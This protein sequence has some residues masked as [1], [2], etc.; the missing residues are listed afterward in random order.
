MAPPQSLWAL[1]ALGAVLLGDRWLRGTPGGAGRSWRW[2][3]RAEAPT[4]WAQRADLAGLAVRRPV[5]GRV[6][7]GRAR[8]RLV[9][10]EPGQAL[11]VVGPT[12]S[13]KTSGLVVPALL[14]WPGPVVAAS[15]KADLVRASLQARLRLGRVF[16]YDPVQ[17]AGPGLW[18]DGAEPVGWTPVDGATSWAGARR[19]ASALASVAR[20][21][22]GDLRDG[23]FWYQQAAKLLGPLLHAAALG[24]L[25]VTEV[26]RW[27]ETQEAEEPG[28][29]LDAAGAW[30]ALQ[31]LRACW[32]R[33][34][35]QRSA[36]LATA[37]LVLE[38]YAEPGLA[39]GPGGPP[40]DPAALSAGCDSLFLC[41][42]AHHQERLRP[43]FAALLGEVLAGAVDRAE[44]HGRPLDPPLLVVVDE[45]ANVA[46]LADLDVLAAT[47]AAHGIQLV[48]VW[49]DLAQLQARY[50]PRAG[51]V[52]NNHRARLFLPGIADPATLEHASS[53]AG[54]VER[55]SRTV[56]R[57]AQ[58]RVG[59][60]QVPQR[61]RLLPPDALRRLPTR[62]GLLIVGSRQPCRV[63]LVP[64]FDDPEL[65]RLARPGDEEPR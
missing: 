62:Q 9:C 37:E 50:G 4:R 23:D 54:D 26:L 16:L 52:L 2:R 63:R 56:S 46:P 5:P 27:L 60:A 13:H 14:R 15:V 8:G 10:L 19:L 55:P 20:S 35:R 51:T 48:T 45:A 44:R 22:A 21:R 42:P 36:V 65:R 47:V 11:A 17:V 25:P 1:G 58:G 41:A 3:T 6:V 64:W 30:P 57:D 29:L 12:Q 40:L 59:T 28:A 32:G 38:A 18:A 43:L 53:L 31:A 39:E 33:D 34:D 24:G 49:Q 61:Q 7:V